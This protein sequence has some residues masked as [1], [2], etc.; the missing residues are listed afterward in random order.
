MKLFTLKFKEIGELKK[1]GKRRRGEYVE[2]IWQ[3]EDENSSP[4]IVITAFKSC[5]NAVKRNRIRRIIRNWAREHCTTL[6]P[7]IRLFFRGYKKIPANSWQ[8]AK[9]LIE[10]DLDKWLFSLQ[11]KKEYN[12]K[13]GRL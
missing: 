7:G 2:I 5:G 12:K 11:Q 10:K 13:S 9:P 6:P 4:K 3:I 8:E 1:K